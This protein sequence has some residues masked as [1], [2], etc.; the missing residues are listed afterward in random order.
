LIVIVLFG[1]ESIRYFSLALLIGVTFGT[2]S[3]VF[4]ASALLV[5]SYNRKLKTNN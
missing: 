2:Y 5:S 3:S 4:V 1:G